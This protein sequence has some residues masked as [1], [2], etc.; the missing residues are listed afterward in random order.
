MNLNLTR[1]SINPLVLAISMASPAVM[2]D[3]EGFTIEE[4]VV[5]AQRREQSLQDVPLSVQ[6]LGAEQ[7]KQNSVKALSDISALTPGLSIAGSQQ[8]SGAEIS[9]RG[10]S[11]LTVSTGLDASTPTYIDGV[12]L[13]NPLIFREL[14]DIERIEVLRGP[15]G[16]LFGRNAAAGAINVTT[17]APTEELEGSI[18]LGYGS[19]DLYTLRGIVNVPLSDSV[20]S[21]TSVAVRNRDGYIDSTNGGNDFYEQDHF[22]IRTRLA[23]DIS[24]SVSADFSADHYKQNDLQGP[25]ITDRVSEPVILPVPIPVAPFFTLAPASIEPSRSLDAGSQPSPT[26]ANGPGC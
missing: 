9:V 5:T 14:T 20:R 25:V 19:N 6:A 23:W 3:S 7:L 22:A 17:V 24:D 21:R 12:F 13:E 11:T 16:T 18:E 15:Q 1:F 4:V 2:A 26:L 10:V 8:G